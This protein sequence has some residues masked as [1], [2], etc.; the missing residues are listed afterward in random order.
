MRK[1]DGWV[2]WKDRRRGKRRLDR[3][4]SRGL[5][6]LRRRIMRCAIGPRRGS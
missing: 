1:R 2:G 5:R 3:K 4:V 6:R